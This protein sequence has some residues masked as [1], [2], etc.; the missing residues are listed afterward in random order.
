MGWCF[1]LSTDDDDCFPEMVCLL[2]HKLKKEGFTVGYEARGGGIRSEV[3]I[4]WSS[5]PK[6][7]FDFVFDYVK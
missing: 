5:R 6:Y 7:K 3:T 4:S 1:D 2:L